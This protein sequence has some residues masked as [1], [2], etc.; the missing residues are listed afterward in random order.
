MNSLQKR[1]D[2]GRQ[3]LNLNASLFPK[4]HRETSGRNGD[5]AARFYCEMNLANP[6]KRGRKREAHF[7]KVNPANNPCF[8]HPTGRAVRPNESKPLTEKNVF[9]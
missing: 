1:V 9:I 5:S 8:P 4:R 2:N 3:R 6:A 7:Q